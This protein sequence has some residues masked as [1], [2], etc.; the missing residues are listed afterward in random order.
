[1]RVG[2][3]ASLALATSVASA[4][5]LPADPLVTPPT[6]PEPVPN[7]PPVLPQPPQ[8][9]VVREVAPVAPEEV[10]DR[11]TGFSIGIGVGYRLPTSLQTPNTASV[12]FRLPNAVTFEPSVILASSSREVD[13]GMTQT[14][15]A[16][17]V[18]VGVLARLPV[19]AR[20]RT[21]LEVLASFA[22]NRA[23]ED[24]NDSNPDDKLEIST[25]SLGYGVAVG[26][27]AFRNLNISLSATNSLITYAHQREEMGFGFVSV[28]NTTSFGLIFDPTV[29][30]M[31]HLYN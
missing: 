11:P 18:G 5:P 22:A 14:A 17:E 31:F 8:P 1:M 26:F 21:A 3:F 12:R 24:P 9:P 10:H 4:Q 20:K 16:S 28:T 29:T 15:T 19:M 13:V 7:P 2:L 6:A 25:V 27:W 30:L 23:S